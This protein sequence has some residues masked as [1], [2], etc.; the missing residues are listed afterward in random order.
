MTVNKDSAAESLPI[1]RLFPNVVTIIGLCFGL[2]ALKFAI[3][4][5]WETS[6]IFIIIAAVIDGMDG[7]IA[8]LLNATSSFGAQL[9][10]LADFFNFGVA[11][12]LV[13][14]MWSAHSIKGL[15]WA[16]TLFFVISQALRLARFNVSLDDDSTDDKEVSDNFFTGIPAPCG[17]GLSLLPMML[18]FFFEQRL[19]YMPFEITP[20]MVILY[21]ALIAILMVS[22]IPTI[23][24]KKLKIRRKSASVALAV[25]GILVVGIIAEPWV[26]LPIIG[27]G[28]LAT[29]PFSVITY[30]KLKK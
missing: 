14:Y 24:I 30:Y 3:A 13:L 26:L 6:V 1:S 28:Y 12:A 20:L 8:R 9:D 5:R 15:G 29:I 4:E 11:P 23:S 7:R 16:V 17:A 21:M 18:T 2:F 19:G 27:L 10:S 25:I 22:R